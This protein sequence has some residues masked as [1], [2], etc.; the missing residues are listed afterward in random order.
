MG[1]KYRV[2]KTKFFK[3]IFCTVYAL[4]FAFS[5]LMLI[6]SEKPEHNILVGDL[7]LI[8]IVILIMWWIISYI[9]SY[10]FYKIKQLF[11][12]S[13]IEKNNDEAIKY[14]KDSNKNV[15]TDNDGVIKSYKN[16]KKAK[17]EKDKQNQKEERKIFIDVIAL[18]IT[19][20]TLIIKYHV[21][22][23]LLVTFIS[24]F[25]L[26]KSVFILLKKLKE[27]VA[28]NTPKKITEE[29]KVKMDKIIN[30]IKEKTETVFYRAICE[31]A[32][33][34][35]MFSSKLG[36]IPY[37][38]LNRKYPTDSKGNKLALLAQINFEKEKF[39]DERMPKTGIV[40]IFVATD[41]T[42]GLNFKAQDVQNDWKIIYH[43]KINMNI[44]E[45]D[46]LKLNI[47]VSTRLDANKKEYFPFYEEYLL[48]FEKSIGCIGNGI[49]NFDDIIENI[50]K[51][52]FNE[53]MSEIPS[54]EYFSEEEYAYLAKISEASGHKVLGYPC[55]TQDDP[56]FRDNY[57][58]YDT[59]LLQ[60]DS[61]YSEDS[62]D[63]DIMWG[64][65][66]VANF[67]INSK[68]LKNKDFSKV[69]YNWDCY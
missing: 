10:V 35:D 16:S 27:A 12:G 38:D 59:L 29:S 31:K 4:W 58:R 28:L 36:G 46:I 32:E 57:K 40:Q 43:E 17:S 7:I 34:I 62:E 69:L 20:I 39:E 9:I 63:D 37:W 54:F 1:K 11:I 53:D 5:L 13:K 19:L 24:V 22:G 45:E 26:L 55:F 41:E 49:Y 15:E 51:E 30:R 8:D 48:K 2:M 6:P 66:G 65:Y 68:D 23:S 3:R 60:I 18:I 14:Y 42:Y 67:F 25:I 52:L 50:V 33:N 47:P 21:L 56:R 61:E 44:K 64:D